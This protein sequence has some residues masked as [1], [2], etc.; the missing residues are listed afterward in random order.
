MS[1]REEPQQKRKKRMQRGFR[2]MIV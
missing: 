2:Y 1:G